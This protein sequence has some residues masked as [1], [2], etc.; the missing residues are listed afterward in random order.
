MCISFLLD[1]VNV[2]SENIPIE[3]RSKKKK[4]KQKKK[5]KRK[6]HTP[7]EERSAVKTEAPQENSMFLSLGKADGDL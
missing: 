1:F 2:V 6:R 3:Q 7:R 5:K 4:H